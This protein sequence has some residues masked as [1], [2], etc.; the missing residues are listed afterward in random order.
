MTTHCGWNDLPGSV[1]AAIADSIGPVS[2]SVDLAVGQNN[3]LAVRL[4]RP[5]QPP[6]FCKG[7][8]GG[9]RRGMFLDNEV[10]ANGLTGGIAPVVLC[11][12]ELDDWQ[13]VGFEFVAGRRADLSPGS[14]DLDLIARTVDAVSTLSAGE[15]R[16]LRLRWHNTDWWHRLATESPDTVRDQDVDEWDRFAAL[17]PALVDGDRLL[18]TDLHADQFLISGERVRV[19]DWAFPGAG[20]PWVDAAFLVIRL[21]LAGHRIAE[22]EAW[23]RGL[24]CWADVSELA[25]TAFAA[26]IAGMW[27]YWAATTP[28]PGTAHRAQAARAYAA[29]RINTTVGSR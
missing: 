4:D 2:G 10:A 21:I 9:G 17:C 3:D 11:G 14:A 7:V 15:I 1:R 16:P 28:E 22:A 5:G 29:W 18:H 26:Y 23:A 6:V 19:I 13:V 25:I 8:R 27:S 24:R 12:V 20:A